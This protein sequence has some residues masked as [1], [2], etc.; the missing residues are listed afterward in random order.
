MRALVVTPGSPSGLVLGEAP[1]P[2]PAPNETLIEV[3]ASSLNFGDVSS[4]PNAAPGSVPGWDAAGVVV[5]AAEDGSGPA[6]GERVVSFGYAGGAWGGLRAVPTEELAVV[7]AGVDLAVAAALPVAGVTALRA[8]R[9]AGPLIGRRVLV[10][11]ASGGVGRYAVQLAAQGG[12][13][14]VAA[15]RRDAG[16]AELGAA[17]V[18]SEVAGLAPVDVVIE[19][20]GGATLV[21]AWAALAPGGSLQSIGWTSGEPAVFPP[22]AT[23][24]LAKSLSAFQLGS[25]LGADLDYLM[26]LVA[27]GRLA[28]DVGWRGSWRR[29]DEAVAG[30]LGR[31]FAGKAVLDHD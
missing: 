18:V 3:A 13:H 29:F 16:L 28:V 17:E 15:S 10:T 1:D 20:V 12:A 4:A 9:A 14:V 11:G 22:Y 21:G 25:A 5:K 24:G 31:A 26:E 7:P 19:N 2:A 30:L 8:L 27:A 6:A 23:V